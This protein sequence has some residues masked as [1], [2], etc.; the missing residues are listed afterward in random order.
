MGSN[1]EIQKFFYI[2]P[3]APAAA[4]RT[5]GKIG[6]ILYCRR[7]PPPPHAW[8]DRKNTILPTAP[9]DI[10]TDIRSP[11]PPTAPKDIPH[12]RAANTQTPDT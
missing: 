12:V 2:L 4:A 5:H 9:K 3:T 10:P 1:P 8:E 6:K 7:P 11:R